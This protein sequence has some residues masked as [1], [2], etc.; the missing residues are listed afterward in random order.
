MNREMLYK[1]AVADVMR[2]WGSLEGG[3]DGPWPLA[4][5][6]SGVSD[7]SGGFSPGLRGKLDCMNILLLVQLIVEYRILPWSIY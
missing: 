2:C 1:Y 4:S 6:E 7:W 5:G 3:V